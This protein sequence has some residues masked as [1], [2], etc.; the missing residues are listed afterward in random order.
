[1]M[2]PVGCGF[3]TFRNLQGTNSSRNGL[4]AEA[5]RD[6]SRPYA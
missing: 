3:I 6:K 5:E 4:S 2:K 1:M